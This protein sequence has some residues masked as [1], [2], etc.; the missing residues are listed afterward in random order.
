MT[1]NLYSAIMPMIP[2]LLLVCAFAGTSAA[3][4]LSAHDLVGAIDEYFSEK[5]PAE[6]PGAV[7]LAIKDGEIILRK[8]YGMANIEL[9]VR[10]T[11]NMVFRIGSITKQFTAACIMM[12][13]EEGK[14]SLNDEITK[15]IP[16]YPTGG[17]KITIHNLLNHTSG[18]KSYDDI[19]DYYSTIRDDLEP[20]ELVNLFKNEP[21]DF[22]PGEQFRYSNSG[23][24]LLGIIIERISGKTFEEY[25]NERIFRPL[26]MKN[27][28]HGNHGCII[29]NRAAGYQQADTGFVNADYL[30]MTQFT[31]N[32]SLLSTADDLWI[33]TKALFS[34]KLLSQESLRLMTTPAVYAGGKTQDYGYGLWLKPLFGEKSISHNGGINGFLTYVIYLPEKDIFVAV[35]TNALAVVNAPF[36]GEWTAALLC[37]KDVLRKPAI[38]LDNAIIDGIEGIYE[39]SEGVDLA[40]TR[41]GNSIYSQKTNSQRVEVFASSPTEFFYKD[42]FSHFSVVREESGKVTK[43]IMHASGP[44]EEAIMTDRIPEKTTVIALDAGEFAP[45]VGTYVSEDGMEITIIQNEGKFYAQLGDQPKFEIFPKS[46]NTFFFTVAEATLEFISNAQGKVIGLT[47]S[48]GGRNL[49][50]KRK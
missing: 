1:R 41:E 26:G 49:E 10:M 29:P 42:S 38:T 21:M 11:P 43:I 18:I 47:L 3:Q 24:F 39:I 7:V 8:G 20:D 46:Q 33:W 5:I 40:I 22:R 36:M 13:T 45:Y 27:S 12:L 32:G 17:N 34:G 35:L 23:Y 31:A 4:D 15:F 48:Q 2:A 25:V 9:G 19:S 6:G 14:I 37:G 50:M 44:D 30:S 28:N 16:D